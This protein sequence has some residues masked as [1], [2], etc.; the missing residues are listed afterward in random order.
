MSLYMSVFTNYIRFN[1][2]VRSNL[3]WY[4]YILDFVNWDPM[5]NA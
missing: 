4:K 5:F 3:Y 2:Y 1:K